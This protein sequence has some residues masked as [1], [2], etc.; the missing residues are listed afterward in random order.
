MDAFMDMAADF[1]DSQP[2]DVWTDA[3]YMTGDSYDLTSSMCMLQTIV[4]RAMTDEPHNT[5]TSRHNSKKLMSF[6][7]KMGPQNYKILNA[8]RHKAENEQRVV[9]NTLRRAMQLLLLAGH[10]MDQ[11]LLAEHLKLR[12]GHSQQCYSRLTVQ[13]AA[14]PAEPPAPTESCMKKMRMITTVKKDKTEED[15]DLQCDQKGKQISVL[16]GRATVWNTG[17]NSLSPCKPRTMPTETS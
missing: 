4:C 12:N 17:R 11:L 8:L 15:D 7:T 2:D 1:V 14:R 13:Q 3:F 5:A 6:K 10:R 16:A 9:A